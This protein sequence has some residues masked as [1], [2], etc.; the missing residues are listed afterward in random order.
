M[1]GFVSKEDKKVLQKVRE[2]KDKDVETWK[3]MI[4]R[5]SSTMI[6]TGLLMAYIGYA[7]EKAETTNL[8]LEFCIITVISFV[9]VMINFIGMITILGKLTT[10]HKE[11]S[12]K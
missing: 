6:S 5:E 2:N 9:Y 4:R 11:E 8:S 3:Y 12:E 1:W 10:K 7:M